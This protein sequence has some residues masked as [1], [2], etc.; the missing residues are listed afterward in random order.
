ML[1]NVLVEKHLSTRLLLYWTLF[2]HDT[3]HTTQS[4]HCFG[5]GFDQDVPVCLFSL[6]A[7]EING[8]CPP[9]DQFLVQST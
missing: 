3:T 9:Q 2:S 1:G 6:D 4:P 7:Q 5:C 8:A